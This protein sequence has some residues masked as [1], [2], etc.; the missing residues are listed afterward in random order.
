MRRFDF[1]LLKETVFLDAGA[2]MLKPNPVIDEVVSY[3]RD[4]PINLHSIDSKLGVKVYDKY[5]NAKKIVGELVDADPSEII[6]TSG[7]T[8]SLNRVARMFEKFVKKGDKIVVSSYNH[9][10]NCV[11][12]IKLAERTGAI[13]V[14]SKDLFSDIDE[15]TKVVAYSQVNN[16]IH[17]HIDPDELAD[18]VEK[19]GAVLVNDAAQAVNT[20]KVSLNNSDVIAFSG[21]KVYGPTG[22]GAL[23]IKKELLG[24]LDPQTYG[25]GAHVKYNE[26]EVI[27]KT[28]IEKFEAG[29][30]HIAGI[31]G[32]AAGIEYMNEYDD[33]ERKKD[34]SQYA[35]KLL[36]E[37][38][39][40]SFL[41]QPRDGNVIFRIEGKPS[42]DIVS[43]LGHR[44]VILRSGK[45]CA[46][47]LFDEL[48]ISDAIRMSFGLYNNEE[49]IE[50]AVE[51]IKNG[52]DF[53]EGF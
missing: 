31:I 30:L 7:T 47:Y 22:I 15:S 34:L 16:T 32:M 11:P 42:Q 6:F 23:V 25:G 4:Y 33:F 28:G 17:Q 14:F 12:W 38:E 26:N 2:G 27:D 41:S 46:L 44:N 48:G 49:D 29:T 52:G 45:Q 9:S 24:F 3:Y 13:V 1:P 40:I 39:G 19:V 36:S 53:L 8:D 37:V 35:H 10:S 50:K 21:T 43:Y 5:N 51:L 18:A 20:T